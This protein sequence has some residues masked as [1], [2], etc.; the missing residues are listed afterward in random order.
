M[1]KHLFYTLL[2]AVS[3]LCTASSNASNY[4]VTQDVLE[5]LLALPNVSRED[6]IQPLAFEVT[7]Q[8]NELGLDFDNGQL[9]SS[10]DVPPDPRPDCSGLHFRGAEATI[11]SGDVELDFYLH[12]LAQP[13]TMGIA[14]SRA[15]VDGEAEVR[16]I[17]G[18]DTWFGCL[19]LGRDTVQ[20]E[21][22]AVLDMALS[23]EI[24]LN[25]SIS[26]DGSVANITFDPEVDLIGTLELTSLDLT[27]HDFDS[28]WILDLLNLPV[29]GDLLLELLP[30]G[31][32]DS[33]D[34][35]EAAL[36]GGSSLTGNYDAEFD[37]VLAGPR[38]ALQQ[39]FDAWSAHTVIEVP[40][41]GVDDLDFLVDLLLELGIQTYP[42]SQPL[43]EE[44]Q[45]ELL[46][47]FLAG[48]YDYVQSIAQSTGAC[49]AAS[50]FMP[51]Q[52]P[53]RVYT[54]QHGQCQRVSLNEPPNPEQQ[55]YS[56]GACGTVIDYYPQ[57]FEQ[58]CYENVE[59]SPNSKLGNAALIMGGE[60]PW[61]PAQGTRVD[62]HLQEIQRNTVPLYKRLEYSA[63]EVFT[64][65]YARDEQA[66]AAYVGQCVMTFRDCALPAG[67]S[68][69]CNGIS[70]AY[71][72][73][74]AR[75]P[76]GQS[77]ADYL[78][79][80]GDG[81][82]QLEMRVYRENVTARPQP[83]VLALHGG[84]F[85]SRGLGFFGLESLISELTSQGHPVFVPFYRLAG[86]HVDGNEECSFAT[87][88]ETTSD[89]EAALQWVI[90]H[91]ADY[92]ART[93]DIR[94]FGQ[95]AGAFYALW[96]AAYT[97]HPIEKI[98]LMYPP[99]SAPDFVQ[100]LRN[101]AADEGN[102]RIYYEP[103]AVALASLLDEP[104]DTVAEDHP[105]MVAGDLAARLA[106]M[107]T[108]LPEIYT[109]TGNADTL[110]PSRQ[111]GL[112]CEALG[113]ETGV[114]DNLQ[115]SAEGSSAW[116]NFK[117]YA[118][119]ESRLDV[120]DGAGHALE[121]C[122]NGIACAAGEDEGVRRDVKWAMSRLY[123]WL[124]Q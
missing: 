33:L 49:L 22:D 5:L 107:E 121:Y 79:P 40:L 81:T 68:G 80:R 25:P 48:D 26:R 34:L 77:P 106:T 13:I 63:M 59:A 43:L 108:D 122:V 46:A 10:V 58:Y 78:I 4:T 94:I 19:R 51:S 14:V 45:L 3:A 44:L 56:D 117:R 82:C 92:G 65:L 76:L 115:L 6:V 62:F 102:D 71:C 110:V 72:N 57:T 83:P 74:L 7:K 54:L 21:Y 60:T 93:D 116:L 70:M 17:F 104:L 16:Y 105:G 90:D 64:D 119:G 61:L 11:Y 35:L 52:P 20:I 27:F 88:D 53:P 118:C 23:A 37:A 113:G 112:L 123:A 73:A 24:R 12:A 114:G 91:G 15:R 32:A 39:R 89:I 42:L 101:V 124:T 38:N 8:L 55:F 66:H 9:I 120:V 103:V 99:S 95:S 75:L 29:I 31:T 2:F 28:Q 67:G 98:G 50:S 41:L 84:S 111:S 30:S 100:M 96:L 47:A 86:K 1:I 109:I 36:A 87:W 69:S 97:D 85:T 18:A